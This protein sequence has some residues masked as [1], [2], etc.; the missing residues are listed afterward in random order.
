[1]ATSKRPVSFYI[2][3][4][5]VKHLKG[6]LTNAEQQD[7]NNWLAASKQNRDLFRE[8]TNADELERQVQE[9][10]K[11]NTGAAWQRVEQQTLK[12]PE[13]AGR[14]RL[15]QWW[16][17]AAAIFILAIGGAVIWHFGSDK[18]NAGSVLASKY[19]NDVL[20]GTHKARLVLSNGNTV[21][22]NNGADSAFDD[23][24]LAIHIAGG[25]VVYE[26]ATT[27]ITA[28]YNTLYI[29]KGG[30]YM[31]V[32]SDGTKVWLNAASALR[33]PLQFDGKERRVEL[34]E[35]E[36]YFEVAKNEHKPFRVIMNDVEIR[37]I[38]TAFNVNG[39]SSSNGLI[40]A[41]LTEGVI[42]V[43]ASQKSIVLQPGEQ[44]KAND[45]VMQLIK[46]DTSLAVA[47][48][49]GLFMY[50]RT[51]LEDVME[52]VARWYDVHVVYDN[53]FT[54]KKFFTGE[55]KRSLPLSKI[56]EMMELT[57]IANFTIENKTVTVKPYNVK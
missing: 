13:R 54:E 19:G 57:G 15:K 33:Y 53:A 14:K 37:D 20:P 35:G 16:Q 29:P 50:E 23:K 17:V 22:L 51:P 34:L 4:L 43:V 45:K 42:K 10:D 26:Q 49:N 46:V 9:L 2:A 44:V 24:G 28:A 5:I 21:V 52:Q 47:W 40:K 38:G 41:T 56:L 8:L 48:K 18:Q 25:R 32:L 36:A 30:E 11:V 39:Y 1:M 31:T 55:I 3:S 27:N 6:G 7:L 12:A